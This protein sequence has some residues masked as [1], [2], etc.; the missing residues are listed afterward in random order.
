V[1]VNTCTKSKNTEAALVDI[2]VLRIYI[3]IYIYSK[4]CNTKSHKNIVNKTLENLANLVYL[5]TTLT[6]KVECRK[7]LISDS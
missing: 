4:D 2:D 5:L 3:Y 7:T 6:S 1:G